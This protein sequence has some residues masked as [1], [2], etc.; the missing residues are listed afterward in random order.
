MLV[1]HYAPAFVAK[2][3]APRV[4]LWTLV[5][6]V[7]LVDIAWGL[8]VLLGVE[9]V[10]IVP[11]LP[12][13]PLDLVYMPYTHSLLAA[14]GWSAL[15]FVLGRLVLGAGG[16]AIV[17]ALAVASHWV[18]DLVVHRPD[19]PLAFGPERLGLALWNRPV[20]AYVVEVGLLASAVAF[21][22]SRCRPAGLAR[23]TATRLVAALV[24]VQ[25]LVV[26]VP[27]PP[28]IPVPVIVLSLLGLFLAVVWAA[29]RVE[30]T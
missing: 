23:R 29:A 15:A 17:L 14:V 24:V 16:G 13:N 25:T 19:L 10:R 1:G 27:L 12:S 11:G 28:S 5:A 4:P 2:G 7:Q 8:L 18:L 30:A 3:I 20:L 9:Q 26:F 21:W 22:A 6:A